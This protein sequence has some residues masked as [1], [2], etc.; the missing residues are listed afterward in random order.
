L[1]QEQPLASDRKTLLGELLLPAGTARLDPP[2]YLSEHAREFWTDVTST[3]GP[4]GM[5]SAIDGPALAVL[6]ENLSDYWALRR[7]LQLLPDAEGEK[8]KATRMQL[9][10]LRLRAL[11][12]IRSLDG[13]L[14]SWLGDMLMTPSS[15]ARTTPVL[16]PP[17]EAT[18][19]FSMLDVDERQA[20]REMLEKRRDQPVAVKPNGRLLQ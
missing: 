8:D 10:D 14:R 15:R 11:Q 12:T 9:V 6:C 2:D 17:P 7:D 20:L 5:L 13:S 18:I 1:A 3:L 4:A 19:D 16:A